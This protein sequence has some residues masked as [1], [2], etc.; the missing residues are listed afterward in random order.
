[1]TTRID[2]TPSS[3]LWSFANEYYRA[4]LLVQVRGE[5]VLAY[6]TVHYYLVCHSIELVLKAF[7]RAKGYWIQ[8]LRDQFGHDLEL[9]LTEARKQGLG[10]FCS[11]SDEFVEHLR[12]ANFYYRLKD[13]EYIVAGVMHLPSLD[14]L[15][16][17]TGVLVEGTKGFCLENWKLHDGKPS[18]YVPS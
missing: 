1:V 2:R 4:A 11:V 17:G 16:T 7:L 13:F 9:A 15:L 8:N 14:V 12:R 18:A 10:E 3:G 6:T 5:S